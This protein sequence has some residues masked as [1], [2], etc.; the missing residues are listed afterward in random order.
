MSEHPYALGFDPAQAANAHK[1]VRFSAM[2]FGDDRLLPPGFSLS[3]Y[4]QRHL[5]QGGAGTCWLHAP[6]QGFEVTTIS[7]GEFV[8]F[9]SCRML[10]GYQGTV[11][12]A[13]ASGGRRGNPTNGGFGSAAY[14]AMSDPPDGVGTAREELWPYSDRS[15]DLA[16]VPSEAV[17]QDAALNRIHQVTTIPALG[18]AVKRAIFN[19]HPCPIGI[20][21]PYGWDQQ[22]ATVFDSIGAGTYGHELLIMGWATIDGKPCWQLD[23]WHGLLYRPLS[24]AVAAN[25]P[26]Y[27][28]IQADKTSDF[29]VTDSALQRVIGY[30]NAELVTAAGMTGYQRRELSIHEG[31]TSCWKG[32]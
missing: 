32:F 3:T 4:R 30:G 20:W 27:K 2:N 17:K 24:A 28:P 10:T 9:K 19:G 7:Q 26:G 1:A 11:I 5:E 6:T 13:K 8:P 18:D 12:M 14:A 15:S 16:G 25:V 21:W 29:W 22:G 23:N 31:L